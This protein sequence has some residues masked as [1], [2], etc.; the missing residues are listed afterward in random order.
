[1]LLYIVQIR[2][3]GCQFLSCFLKNTHYLPCG[4]FMNSF[5]PHLL[6]IGIALHIRGKEETDMNKTYFSASEKLII[7][8]DMSIFCLLYWSPFSIYLFKC[9]WVGNHGNY[10]YLPW[11]LYHHCPS[12]NRTCPYVPPPTRWQCE[13][14][15]HD[16]GL[17]NPSAQ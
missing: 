9:W 13:L 10:I 1:M 7:Y 8:S 4:M 17:A 6:I 16:L 11:K 2:F 12:G 15:T 5:H 3:S 14:M